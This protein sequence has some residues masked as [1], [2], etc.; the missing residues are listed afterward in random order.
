M[1]VHSPVNPEIEKSLVGLY[2]FL[3]SDT[4]QP[5]KTLH[6]IVPGHLLNVCNVMRRHRSQS[7]EPLF[8]G[9]MLTAFECAHELL[10]PHHPEC[11]QSMQ[12]R[13]AA[14][15]DKQEIC[16]YLLMMFY[17]ITV[18]QN[19]ESLG[20]LLARLDNNVDWGVDTQLLKQTLE[21]IAENITEMDE[22]KWMS[23]LACEEDEVLY[24]PPTPTIAATPRSYPV[25]SA[26]FSQLRTPAKA[27]SPL[28]K[29]VISSPRL[30]ER[31]YERELQDVR[32][33]LY[34]VEDE[35]AANERKVKSLQTRNEEL[36]DA[37][38]R[39][40]DRVETLSRDEAR[41]TEALA[42]AD[43]ENKELKR[44]LGQ[45]QAT[46]DNLK[47]SHTRALRDIE[48]Y[49]EQLSSDSLEQ[50]DYAQQIAELRRQ[51]SD[52]E[53]S[54]QEITKS[55]NAAER[56]YKV[57]KTENASL[58]QSLAEVELAL[59]AKKTEFTQKT[60]EWELQ[61]QTLEIQ[62][63]RLQ[64]KLEGLES[65]R[66]EEADAHEKEKR[67]FL[68]RQTTLD[69]QLRD[70]HDKNQQAE[71]LRAQ[72]EREHREELAVQM[73]TADSFRESVMQL[74]KDNI[75]L[76]N[77]SA[78]QQQL[79]DKAEMRIK[80]LVKNDEKLQARNLEFERA[81][82]DLISS[83][84]EM[85]KE[86][87]KCIQDQSAQLKLVTKELADARNE[88]T[89]LR[90]SF[91]R[92][93]ELEKQK[94]AGNVETIK[95]LEEEKEDKERQ[96]KDLRLNSDEYIARLKGTQKEAILRAEAAENKVAVLESQIEELK[97]RPI[98]P[99]EN[100]PP[101]SARRLSIA[102]GRTKPMVNEEE[103]SRY[104]ELGLQ[105]EVRYGQSS[106]GRLAELSARNARLPPHLR[107][108]HVFETNS[109]SPTH[110]EHDVRDGRFNP[111][112][113]LPKH[114]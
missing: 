86:N 59:K 10:Q 39:G 5:K 102:P 81:I 92:Q 4:L 8:A 93:L 33:R 111:E 83:H 79:L 68:E 26:Q 36:E 43:K 25:L 105:R 49:E 57:V 24:I 67:R 97:E 56:Q 42:D 104:R 47:T 53:Q 35:L 18:G 80:E 108:S 34:E 94:A 27:D 16:K 90:A 38:A 3:G 96:L 44:Q 45:L 28:M 21:T 113:V 107:D 31:R 76:Q 58:Q 61:L 95:K 37:L 63:A 106:V 77:R 100:Q 50:D 112:E 12:P 30:R 15:G 48:K 14:M 82:E 103:P 13:S 54:E 41:R 11:L 1:S 2:N 60:A 19:E 109:Y 85:E 75:E 74:Q 62:N 46:Y 20:P 78:D 66:N 88:N 23:I 32:R 70:L 7:A 6:D 110:T 89:D 22:H 71:G 29:D 17:E 72:R 64:N 9:D 73:K 91:Q 55:L 99:D 69:A 84:E 114:D 65:T 52:L 101:Q 98:V 51:V 87:R 40:K